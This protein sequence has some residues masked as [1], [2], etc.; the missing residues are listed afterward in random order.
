[1]IPEF[2]KRT[3]LAIACWLGARSV[4]LGGGGRG[5]RR[6]YPEFFEGG[7]LVRACTMIRRMSGGV[8]FGFGFGF[9]MTT[10]TQRVF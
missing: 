5:S 3:W 2:Q 6:R 8:G 4:C 10:Y 1:M 7:E 9:G